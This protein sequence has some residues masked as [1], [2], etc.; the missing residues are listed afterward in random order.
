MQIERKIDASE[1][2]TK[3]DRYKLLMIARKITDGH[4]VMSCLL[5]PTDLSEPIHIHHDEAR[6]EAR[7]RN[8]QTCKSVWACPVCA[9]RITRFRA[10]ELMRGMETWLK[11]GNRIAMATYTLSHRSNESCRAVLNRLQAAYK[12]F[13]GDRAYKKLRVPWGIAGSIRVLELTHGENGWHW[14]IHEIYFLRGKMAGRHE[15]MVNAMRAHWLHV[16]DQ[17]GGHAVGKGFD[18][19]AETKAAF[20]YVTKFGNSSNAK[21]WNMAREITRS[22]AKLRPTNDGM[23]P[24]Q[25]LAA[26]GRSDALYTVRQ[27]QE[28]VYATKNVRQLVY[29]PK[30][31]KLLGLA[32]I[33]DSTITELASD[34]IMPL[35]ARI[36][37]RGWYW[38]NRPALGIFTEFMQV[39][40][41]GDAD[42]LA[43]WLDSHDVETVPAKT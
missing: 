13:K 40:G 5:Y 30:L 27:W 36:T 14:H 15:K 37:I 3:N 21:G 20:D 9:D 12:R 31:K 28:Y 17:V 39:A 24:F 7:L 10:A 2:A 43:A 4:G 38:L 11:E 23:H 34:T 41:H 16:V 22:P 25:I 8:V 26:A 35:L 18:L 32:D 1:N 29:S 42:L 33:D 6:R 19:K